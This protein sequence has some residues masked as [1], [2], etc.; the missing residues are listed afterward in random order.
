M[1][2]DAADTRLTL[3]VGALP[4]V[5]DHAREGSP[6]ASET[7]FRFSNEGPVP[8][9]YWVDQ[10]FGYALSGALPPDQLARL[11]QLVYQPL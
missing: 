4:P 6:P 1:Y 10:G 3:Y 9:F 7:A 5:A 8:G 2:Q 11:V